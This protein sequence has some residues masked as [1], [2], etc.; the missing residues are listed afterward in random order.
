MISSATVIFF[1]LGILM[2]ISS[3][4]IGGPNVSVEQSLVSLVLFI[5][6]MGSLIVSI[7][8]T[9]EVER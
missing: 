8:S 3:C 9:L 1:L 2:I 7:I 6:G 4:L 5:F